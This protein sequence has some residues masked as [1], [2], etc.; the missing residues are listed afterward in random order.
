M[1]MAI[2]EFNEKIFV[3]LICKSVVFCTFFFFCCTELCKQQ[4]KY[5]RKI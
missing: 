5:T 3:Q 4:I 1:L 2:N